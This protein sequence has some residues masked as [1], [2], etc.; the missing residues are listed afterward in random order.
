MTDI[1]VTEN[2][3][4]ESTSEGFPEGMVANPTRVRI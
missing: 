1:E 2:P 4:A 3:Q